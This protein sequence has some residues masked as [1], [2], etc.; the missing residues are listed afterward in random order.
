MKTLNL[1]SPCYNLI[2]RKKKVVTVYWCTLTGVI[3]M[4]ISQYVQIS[5]LYIITL[6]LTDSLQQE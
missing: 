4:L 2:T 3:L 5:N 6:E 1:Q